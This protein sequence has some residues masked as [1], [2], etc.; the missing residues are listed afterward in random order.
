MFIIWK[1]NMLFKKNNAGNASSIRER[2][3]SDGRERKSVR[4][5]ILCAPNG[6]L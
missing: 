4:V 2:R 1:P 3:E 5:E 6:P